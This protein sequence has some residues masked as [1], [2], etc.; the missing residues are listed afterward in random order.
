MDAR[1]ADAF[2]KERVRSFGVLAESEPWSVDLSIA[3][4]VGLIA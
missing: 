3:M 1:E 4:S 2:L